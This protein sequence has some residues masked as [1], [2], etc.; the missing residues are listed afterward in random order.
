MRSREIPVDS[1]LFTS[2]NQETRFKHSSKSYAFFGS[3]KAT[4]SERRS[5]GCGAPRSRS[6]LSTTS[7][8]TSRSPDPIMPA[9]P[10]ARGARRR[11]MQ[12]T[13]DERR[14]NGRFARDPCGV[15]LIAPEYVESSTVANTAL[16]ASPIQQRFQ[17]PNA[18]DRNS[19]LRPIPLEPKAC[20][21]H[22]HHP[23]RRRRL[24]RRCCCVNGAPMVAWSSTHMCKSRS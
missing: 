1:G 3:V 17:T 23:C 22:D 5:T 20:E 9:P 7:S 4:L 13:F 15:G 18:V 21:V 24:I 14:R 6:G 19:S 11:D 8:I 16:C 10:S 12:R 2:L